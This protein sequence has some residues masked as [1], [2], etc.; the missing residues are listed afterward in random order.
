MSNTFLQPMPAIG[1][2]QQAWL[3]PVSGGLGFQHQG[4]LV[5]NLSR[6]S[7]L[8]SPSDWIA[9][10]G[11]E[12]QLSYRQAH[13]K[14]ALAGLTAH[15]ITALLQAPWLPTSGLF[16]Q[17]QGYVAMLQLPDDTWRLVGHASPLRLNDLQGGTGQNPELPIVETGDWPRLSLFC[18][19]PMPPLSMPPFYTEWLTN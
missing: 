19:Q 13:L 10:H 7:A 1:G 17:S 8:A 4:G 5:V 3:L 16:S 9:L 12:V 6:H 11:P 2:L 15:Y 18:H 14:G